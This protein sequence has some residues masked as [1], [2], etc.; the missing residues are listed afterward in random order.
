[1]DRQR[2]TKL[3]KDLEQQGFTLTLSRRNQHYKVTDKTGRQVSVLPSTPGDPRSY[4]NALSQL[5]RA[6]AKV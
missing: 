4:R 5:R 3:R 1:M 2:W 6:G